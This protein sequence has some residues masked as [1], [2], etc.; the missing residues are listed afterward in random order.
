MRC[1][2]I[3]LPEDAVSSSHPW[4]DVGLR[5]ITWHDA[6]HGHPRGMGVIHAAWGW[7]RGQR[8]AQR[9]A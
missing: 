6:C 5:H 8:V 3:P 9:G 1:A 4:D 7:D 2:M